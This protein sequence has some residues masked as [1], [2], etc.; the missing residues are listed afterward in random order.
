MSIMIKIRWIAE[1]SIDSYVAWQALS[2]FSFLLLLLKP[3]AKIRCQMICNLST[4]NLAKSA[5]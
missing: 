3:K 5:V 2:A 4:E 1:P